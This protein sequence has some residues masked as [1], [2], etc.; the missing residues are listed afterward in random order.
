MVNKN[1]KSYKTLY[2]RRWNACPT[3]LRPQGRCNLQMVKSRW[4]AERPLAWQKPKCNPGL[5]PPCI[6]SLLLLGG[7]R[8]VWQENSQ[9]FDVKTLTIVP[10]SSS[11]GPLPVGPQ[12]YAQVT[13]LYWTQASP[14]PRQGNTLLGH[15]LVVQYLKYDWANHTLAC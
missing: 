1:G 10:W 3:I 4:S 13:P 8:S 15:R 12:E 14:S 11:P 9:G 7:Q 6:R 2:M 5:G